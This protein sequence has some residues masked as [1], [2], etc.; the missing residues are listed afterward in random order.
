M[1]SGDLSSQFL[2][3]VFQL[4]VPLQYP[5]HAARP[6]SCLQLLD[7]PLQVLDVLL[8]PLTDVSLR[9]SII[10]TF[11]CQLS[12]A[13]MCYGSLSPARAFLP[14]LLLRRHRAV[15]TGACHCV[16]GGGG[17]GSGSGTGQ[18]NDN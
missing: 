12:F 6:T 7:L 9:L 18:F 15:G 13:Q 16:G 17:G 1:G 8:R 3:L 2:N 4:L 5:L 11:P 10:C 14:R